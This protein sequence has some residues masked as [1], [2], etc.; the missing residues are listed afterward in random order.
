V[1]TYAPEDPENAHLIFDAYTIVNARIGIQFPRYE[2]S[3]FSNNITNVAANYGDIFS[4]A[5]D[6]PGR[7]RFG[8]NRPMTVG[9][10][11]RAYF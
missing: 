1:N 10:Q 9:V 3:L 7:P 6:I 11:G 2:F 5:V 8:T 4:V